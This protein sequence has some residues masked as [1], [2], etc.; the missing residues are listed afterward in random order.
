[1][2]IIEVSEFQISQAKKF[3]STDALFII[4]CDALARK[5]SLSVVRMGDG[6]KAIILHAKGQDKWSF[7]NDPKW[8]KE[9][10]LIDAEIKKVGENL[11]K[12]ASESDYFCPNIYGIQKGNY[13]VMG[14]CE[15][16]DYYGEGLFAHTWAYMGRVNALMKY[17][18][19]I[20]VVCRNANEIA[21]RLFMKYGRRDIEFADYDSW[22]DYDSALDFIG[23]MK[24]HLILISA[25]ASGKYLCV[26]AAK[27]YG[28][29][30]L[31]TGSALINFWSISCL[32]NI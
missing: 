18:G 10:G 22:K 9:Y 32:R 14:I 31:D 19:G 26:E 16:R 12:A 30:V 23:Q 3:I 28:K 27:K 20:G 25:G 11:I 29:V 1:M 8:L 2:N 13:D 17:D 4:V 21:D 6:E 15:P 5:K 24:A 7:L